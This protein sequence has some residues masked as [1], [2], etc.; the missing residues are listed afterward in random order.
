MSQPDAHAT[1]PDPEAISGVRTL[2]GYWP[3]VPRLA[4]LV[5]TLITLDYLLNLGL[6]TVFTRR[7]SQFFYTV[8]TLM[9]PLV[10]LLWPASGRAR[11]DGVPLY[12]AALFLFAAG[13]CGFFA[14]NAAPIVDRG[15]EYG[16]PDYAVYVS[17]LFW[18]VV[19]EAARRAGGWTIGVIVALA[20]IFPIVTADLP[21][22]IQGFPAT[23]SQTAMYHAMSRE[24]IMGIP[25]QAFANLVIGF[26][27]FGVALQHTGGGRFFINLAFGLLGH[28]RGGPA[29]VAIFSSGLM[30]SMSGSVIT[31]VLTTGVLS[32]PAMRRVGFSRSY[33]GG[34]EACASTG[35]VLMPPVMGATAFVM[36]TFLNVPY[37]HIALAA[38]V[39]SILY[40]LGL[41]IQI[42]AYAARHDLKGLPA[43]ELPPL[44]RTLKEGWYFIFVFILLIWMLFFLRRE[45]IAPFYATAL[46]LVINQI[47]PYQRWGWQE[48]LDFFSAAG[49][50]FA[51][52]IAILAG[53]GLLVGALSMTGL[54]GTIANDLI[55][56]AG[57]STL[58]LLLMGALTSF[59]MGIGMTVTA[60]YI[61]L[62]VALAPALIQGAGMNPMAVHLFILYW[63]MLSFITPPVALGA[64]AAATIAG[65]RPMETGL[66]A[67]RLGSVIYFIPFL[68][69]LNPALI[70]QG[71]AAE[72]VVVMAQALVGVLLIAS[73]L[74][75]YLIFV[76]SLC[77]SAVLQ[78]P[79]RIMLVI[80]GVAIAVPGG[81][82]VALSNGQMLAISAVMLVPG[83]A[84]ALWTGR[85]AQGI[86]AG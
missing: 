5:L 54:S 78:W 52:L 26:L 36:A 27:L 83:I 35:G 19:L 55:F 86:Q 23:P 21:G 56:L 75:G 2:N 1:A 12:D 22:P 58:V 34:V 37:G 51:E 70:L 47:L 18:V 71:S 32:I 79:I 85:R 3:W 68:F 49:K 30:G 69:V 46:L 59:I 14:Y 33:A 8:V 50:L 80:A 53:V 11:R 73:A 66:Q 74:Q 44:K 76:G 45:A 72:I 42:D 48:V 43:A 77:A 20:S 28:V 15:W 10:Y 4:T 38:A 41:F 25:L 13:V 29:K 61:F 57:G 62:A 67:M 9:L 81:G 63:G 7:E 17:F 82:P 40:F 16:A 64:F 65:S 6:L 39:P 84:L 24:S 31:N 60:A